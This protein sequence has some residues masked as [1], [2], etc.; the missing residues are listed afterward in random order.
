MVVALREGGSRPPPMRAI[1][2]LVGALPVVDASW[3]DDVKTP[4]PRGLD[5]NASELWNQTWNQLGLYWPNHRLE[6]AQIQAIRVPLA[7]G[8]FGQLARRG[9]DQLRSRLREMHSAADA[10]RRVGEDEFF[11]RLVPSNG[12]AY[13]ETVTVFDQR[14]HGLPVEGTGGVDL[15]R[16]PSLCRAGTMLLAFAEARATNGQE[17]GQDCVPTGVAMKRSSDDGKTWGDI[18]YPV[19]L[20]EYSDRA[21]NNFGNRSASPVTVWE[22]SRG[23][24]HLHYVKGAHSETDCAPKDTAEA[25][26]QFFN[27]YKYS[28]DMGE[29]WSA[30]GLDISQYLGDYRGCMP[31]PD[32]GI[33]VTL[34][35]GETRIVVPCHLGSSYS[36]NGEAIVYYSE[37]VDDRGLP[38]TWKVASLGKGMDETTIT[39]AYPP[40]T[41]L[42]SMRNAGGQNL[43][44][45][46]ERAS[47][48]RAQAVS[49][50]GGT[51]WTNISYPVSLPDPYGEG[52][53]CTAGLGISHPDSQLVLLSNAPMVYGRAQLSIHMTADAGRTWGPAMQQGGCIPITDAAAADTTSP[54]GAQCRQVV[55]SATF[56]DY[57]SLWCA[58]QGNTSPLKAVRY[59][60]LW[61]TCSSPFPFQM[62]C[63]R[64]HAWS[65]KYSHGTF[66][67]R[68]QDAAAQPTPGAEDQTKGDSNT[69]SVLVMAL[70]V[71]GGCM[72]LQ[73]FRAF[74]RKRAVDG[75]VS[76]FMLAYTED[77][78]ETLGM[79]AVDADDDKKSGLNSPLLAA[80]PK[81]REIAASDFRGSVL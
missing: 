33:T 70:C 79:G 3:A 45:Q 43:A 21:P 30:H 56:S 44:G 66:P 19:Q 65:V 4:L 78:R 6:P 81:G 12:T 29:T 61:G 68:L 27:Y 15:F 80:A 8:V 47:N 57:S 23:R 22:E 64:P 5:R 48:T 54:S 17:S 7:E 62:G 24:I 11:R 10:A 51:S 42:V 34:S 69:S 59:G 9:P 2:W 75:T 63:Q 20:D 1:V 71:V 67:V 73:F 25:Q 13:P 55:D 52:S 50:D 35:S 38:K 31:G 37:G 53:L 28:D 76:D 18:S 77:H 32:K 39:V 41:L 46:P 60:V 40:S 14:D 58:P 74:C 49:T 16:I 26:Q 36:E 72:L